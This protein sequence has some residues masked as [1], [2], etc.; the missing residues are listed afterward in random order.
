MILGFDPGFRGGFCLMTKKGSVRSAGPLPL[1]RPNGEDF[2]I[3]V[4]ALRSELSSTFSKVEVVWIEKVHAFV[5]GSRT[6]AFTF[7]RNFEALITWTKLLL[8]CDRLRFA[9][10]SVWKKV[11]LPPGSPKSASVLWVRSHYPNCINLSL[12]SDGVADAI[13]IAEYGRQQL[14]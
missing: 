6:A 10:P 2:E 14:E 13:L 7:G 9:V 8:G 4:C 1:H 5:R 12:D 3:D 11:F